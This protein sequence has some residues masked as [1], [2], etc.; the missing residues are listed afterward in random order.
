MVDLV[1]D[2][3]GQADEDRG[4]DVAEVA[5]ELLHVGRC[6]LGNVGGEPVVLGRLDEVVDLA[7]D[8]LEDA[9]F[10]LFLAGAELGGGAE[11]DGPCGGGGRARFDE[12]GFELGAGLLEV[13]EV[14][15]DLHDLAGVFGG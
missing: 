7:V 10:G 3:F 12:E 9:D 2:L 5:R 15:E 14:G 13:L 11:G 1:L 6:N 4:H 8:Q